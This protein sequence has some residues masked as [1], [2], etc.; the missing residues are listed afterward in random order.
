MPLFSDS[1]TDSARQSEVRRGE[2]CR[3]VLSAWVLQFFAAH[4]TDNDSPTY[5]DPALESRAGPKA[6][7]GSSH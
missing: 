2:C 7:S 5:D 1:E 6:V 4:L 3:S